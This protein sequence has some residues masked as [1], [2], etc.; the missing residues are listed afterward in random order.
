VITFAGKAGAYQS[1]SLVGLNSNSWLP[2]VPAKIR[3]ERKWLTVANT[4]AY[5]N[6]AT[7]TAVKSIIGQAPGAFTVKLF[8]DVIYE[9]L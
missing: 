1:E 9:F 6:T 4:L 3:Q 7:I 2:A 5:Y 8:T